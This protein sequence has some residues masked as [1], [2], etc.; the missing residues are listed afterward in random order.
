M[1]DDVKVLVN[2]R[3]KLRKAP[4]TD[5]MWIVRWPIVRP[6]TKQVAV[7][8]RNKDILAAYCLNEGHHLVGIQ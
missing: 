1:L 4:F 7:G 3:S 2:I 5:V 8:C 6:Y